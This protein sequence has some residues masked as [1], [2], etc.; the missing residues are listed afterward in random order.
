MRCT[1]AVGAVHFGS[2]NTGR[3]SNVSSSHAAWLGRRASCGVGWHAG[4]STKY[5]LL[6]APAGAGA[7][8]R[9]LDQCFVA[10]SENHFLH[11]FESC[12]EQHQK[13]VVAATACKRKCMCGNLAL[14]QQNF[15]LKA[16]MRFMC[17]YSAGLL[18]AQ[19]T[20]QTVRCTNVGAVGES[21]LCK[22]TASL[23]KC[24]PV[25]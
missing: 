21:K 19:E 10:L 17:V 18:L 25:R 5:S 24:Q 8:H 14:K 4:F 16:V 9:E 13:Y 6:G 15:K 2:G 11:Q 20:K 23:S 12:E 3:V 1:S 22:E 7:N